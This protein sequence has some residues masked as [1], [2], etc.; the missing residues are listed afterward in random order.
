MLICRIV[1][2]TR[3]IEIKFFFEQN[4]KKKNHKNFTSLLCFRYGKKK[5]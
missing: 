5:F 2:M 4:Y 3:K 1:T